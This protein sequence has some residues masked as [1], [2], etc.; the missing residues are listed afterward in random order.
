[1]EKRSPT[2]PRQTAQWSSQRDSRSAVRAT[3]DFYL[4]AQGASSSAHAPQTI[5]LAGL[6]Q[7]QSV[8]IIVHPQHQSIR[9]KSQSG[10]RLG[11]PGVANDIVDA[12][13]ENQINMPALIDTQAQAASRNAEAK[14]YVAGGQHVAGKPAHALHQILK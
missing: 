13:L 12:L 8:A 3:G 11:T 1:M 4:S 7:I 9:F 10:L 2:R 5:P 6:L 14:F